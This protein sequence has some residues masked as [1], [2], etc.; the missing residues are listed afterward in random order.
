MLVQ[1]MKQ[2]ERNMSPT[3]VIN[4][5]KA[6]K[7]SD[8]S[9]LSPFLDW[10]ARRIEMAL[11]LP[12]G[13]LDTPSWHFRNHLEYFWQYAARSAAD[14]TWFDGLLKLLMDVPAHQPTELQ[15]KSKVE[16]PATKTD[17]A[18]G[19]ALLQQKGTLKT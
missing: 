15:P 10:R 2:I 17:W 4:L 16:A 19:R 3:E 6:S 5:V 8:G 7:S 11:D 18:A 9:R 12:M 13:C 1:L 14:R